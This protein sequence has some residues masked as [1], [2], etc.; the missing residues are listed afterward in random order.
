MAT[1]QIV[2]NSVKQRVLLIFFMF[3]NQLLYLS[4]YMYTT[5]VQKYC[6][7]KLIFINYHQILLCKIL[8]SSICTMNMLK[9]TVNIIK[10]IDIIKTEWNA[11]RVITSPI[12][13]G[14]NHLPHREDVNTIN[15]WSPLVGQGRKLQEEVDDLERRKLSLGRREDGQKMDFVVLT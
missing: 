12:K 9:L 14:K 1:F 2:S 11:S 8:L 6:M 15:N 7:K 4:W 10:T 3:S 5:W 13:K